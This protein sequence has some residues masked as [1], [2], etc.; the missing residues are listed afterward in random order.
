MFRA[1]AGRFT[2]GNLAWKDR[3]A[4][5]PEH[6]G[7]VARTVPRDAGTSDGMLGR[8]GKRPKRVI[9]PPVFRLCQP[10]N[11]TIGGSGVKHST[12]SR[13]LAG[14]TSAAL[15]TGAVAATGTAAHAAAQPHFSY[16]N[17]WR[18]DQHEQE[19]ADVNGDN[20]AEV[21]GFGYANTIVEIL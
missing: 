18:V 9:L 15:T 1:G 14:A 6:V 3:G 21:V 10:K 11:S 4:R 7:P 13:L 2:E 19:L 12:T 17:G 8:R 16:T 20:R 5:N